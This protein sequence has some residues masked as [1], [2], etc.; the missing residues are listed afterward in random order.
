MATVSLKNPVKL[1]ITGNTET[2]L[3]LR[4]EFVRIREN[5]EIDRECIVAGIIHFFLFLNIL[6]ILQHVVF[7]GLVTR[8]FPDH[9][10]VFVKTK[11]TCRRLHVVLSLLGAKVS[12]LKFFV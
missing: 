4:Q 11:K 2:A 12:S 1:F 10:I 9:T 5:H 7:L 3:N 6:G 8:N